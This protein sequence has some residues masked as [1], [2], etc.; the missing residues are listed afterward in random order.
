MNVWWCNQ[1]N[2][3]HLERPAGCVC[4]SAET[5]K[6]NYRQ[7][8]GD[9]V[10]GDI[11]VHYKKPKVVAIS[12]AMENGTF[13]KRLP[14]VSGESYGSGW[15]FKTEYIDLMSPVDR[16]L[17]A[18]DLAVFA[19]FGY[20]V[21]PDGAV[22]QGY[23]LPFD[24]A[25]L[26]RI[27]AHVEE[28]LPDWLTLCVGG[29]TPRNRDEKLPSRKEILLSQLQRDRAIVQEIKRLYGNACMLC[30]K[31]IVLPD[32]RLYSEAHHIRPLGG[33]DQGRD[34]LGNLLCVCPNC[35]TELDY[36]CVPLDLKTLSSVLKHKIDTN[37]V[38]YHNR[39]IYARR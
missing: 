38:D 17:F 22:K 24:K 2:D 19:R 14:L 9:V 36:G 5:A 10:A 15:R 11:V 7:T 1:S 8:V 4:A 12:R 32:G 39:H 35:H 37:N 31:T 6:L 20:A 30:G 21:N 33:A 29:K 27:L 13:H 34:E 3:W 16:K 18:Q 25:G 23:F 26:Q 28:D